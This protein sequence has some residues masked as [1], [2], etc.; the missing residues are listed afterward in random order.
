M[1]VDKDKAQWVIFSDYNKFDAR[2]HGVQT[3]R[4]S[5]GVLP[6]D[7]DEGAPQL[8]DVKRAITEALGDVWYVIYSSRGATVEKP[9]WRVF[10]KPSSAVPGAD[11][12]ATQAALFDLLEQ[13]GLTCDRALERTG[14]LVFLPNKGDHYE[15]HIH[16]GPT[17]LH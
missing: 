11:Y 6:V 10:I 8:D 5:F 17:A 16:K 4:G 7:L 14:Q 15:Y 12:A 2:D 3:E 1:S 13:R 9:K